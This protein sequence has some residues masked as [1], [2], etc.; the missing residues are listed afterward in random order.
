MGEMSDEEREIFLEQSATE[1]FHYI[2]NQKTFQ[3][4]L[5]R[6]DSNEMLLEED[7]DFLL[8]K[9]YLIICKAI[10][11]ET[12]VDFIDKILSLVCKMVV[13]FGKENTKIYN[14][15]YKLLE[16]VSMMKKEKEI[17]QDLFT[18]YDTILNDKRKESVHVHLKQQ[19]EAS[20]YRA[21]RDYYL[22]EYQKASSGVITNGERM[23]INSFNRS[24]MREK[25][26]VLSYR[27]MI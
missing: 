3:S 4:L 18:G 2:Y 20:I 25:E 27:N 26:L 17:N 5:K 11:E 9:F 15:C 22:Q 6:L 8:E 19:E 13:R 14:E 1:Y 24:Y 10:S 12:K 16:Y 7:W 21:N 23:A